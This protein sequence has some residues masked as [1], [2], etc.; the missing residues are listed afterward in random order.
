MKVYAVFNFYYEGTA[1]EKLFL[2]LEDAID[3]AN[4]LGE[5]SQKGGKTVL[6]AGRG[7]GVEDAFIWEKTKEGDWSSKSGLDRIYVKELEV[8]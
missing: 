8:E 3:F 2:K 4:I 1:L 7:F 6:S 5:K